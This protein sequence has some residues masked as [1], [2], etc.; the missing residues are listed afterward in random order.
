M[1]LSVITQKNSA[2]GL[3]LLGRLAE[4][5]I[6][7]E[8][9]LVLVAANRRRLATWRR[10][11]R[12]MG[13]VQAARY[14]VR[15]YFTSPWVLRDRTLERRYERLAARVD[16]APGLSSPETSRAVAA[17]RPDL[18]LIGHCGILP[19]AVLAAPRFGT[20]NAHP[21]ILPAYR[22]ND[23][24]LW[25]VL[26]GRFDHLGVTVHLAE[27]RVDRGPILERRPYAL[28]GD[29]TLDLLRERLMA[30]AIDALVDWSR[31]EWPAAI[32]GAE[33]QGDGRLYLSMPPRRRREAARRL[34]ANLARRRAEAAA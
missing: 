28:R 12:Q 18:L 14:L 17:A 16:E 23:T 30:D 15:G 24:D 21:G 33:P 6:A 4:A 13:P 1:R 32:A 34:A 5:G 7:V 2:F 29:E 19:P 3:R 27:R 20:L 25:A 9:A 10:L 22:G 8:Q 26:E 11:A 31:A